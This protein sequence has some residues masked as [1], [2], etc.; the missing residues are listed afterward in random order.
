MNYT[1]PTTTDAVDGSGTATCTPVSGSTF[2]IGPNTVKCSTTDAHNNTSSSTFSVIVSDTIPPVIAAHADEAAEATSPAGA[3]VR[4]LTPTATDDVDGTDGVTCSPASGSTFALGS[5][6]VTCNAADTNH[7]NATPTTFQ[8]V[9]SDSIAP[10][11]TI[12]ADVT[13]EA[14]SASGASVTYT[15][16][17]ASDAADNAVV[18]SCSPA[19]G[20]TFALGSHVVTCDAKDASGNSAKS[21]TFHIIVSDSTAPVVAKNDNINQE[22]IFTK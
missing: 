2:S 12:H 15:A 9:V 8:V 6:T 10:I 21:T 3:T 16:P 20:S 13:T 18:V 7:N 11:I 17:T 5:N 14:T 19:S 1:A 4:Y 22:A